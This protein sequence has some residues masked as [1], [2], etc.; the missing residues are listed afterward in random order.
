MMQQLGFFVANMMKMEKAGVYPLPTPTYA[1][2][3]R[4]TLL[5][6]KNLVL[7]TYDN[8]LSRNDT[9]MLCVSKRPAPCL[10]AR[11]LSQYHCSVSSDGHLWQPE[12]RETSEVRLL[13]KFMCGSKRYC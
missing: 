2:F 5:R 11:S 8:G 7:E 12:R 10:K 1:L 13:Q 4:V 6:F 3:R 9:G